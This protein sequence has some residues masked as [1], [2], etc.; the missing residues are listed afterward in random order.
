MITDDGIFVHMQ[1]YY[2][3]FYA[4]IQGIVMGFSNAL[5]S[6]LLIA[7][8]IWRKESI[9]FYFLISMHA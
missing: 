4:F 1:N 8:P 3:I 9:K 7:T 6:F 2:G 5:S